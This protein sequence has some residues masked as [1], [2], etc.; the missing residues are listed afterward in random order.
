MI[1]KHTSIFIEFEK[2][3]LEIYMMSNKYLLSVTLNTIYI[4]IDHSAR[5]A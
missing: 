3:H 2:R 4:S 5:A 1:W